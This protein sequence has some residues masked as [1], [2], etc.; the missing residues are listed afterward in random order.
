MKYIYANWC[1]SNNFGDLLTPYIIEHL[2]GGKCIYALPS[3]ETLKY[4]VVGTIL[5][6]DIKNTITWGT[7]IGNR[8]D[9]IQPKDIRSVRGKISLNRMEECGLPTQSISLGDPGLILPTIYSP[10]V[11]QSNEIGIV[12]H[13]VDLEYV[14]QTYSNQFTIINPLDSVES[15]VDQILSC[16]Q[17]ISSSLHGLII[18][19]AYGIDT[20]WVKF[21]DAIGGDGTKFHDHY[22]SIDRHESCIDLRNVNIDSILCTRKRIPES[23]QHGLISTCPF[24]SDI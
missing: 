14:I 8:N 19:E 2:S 15:V 21:S 5:N 10:S 9:I 13:Y 3:S 1:L 11:K 18:A 17:I 6:W 16:R 22:S 23:I 20:Q 24:I 12:P 7:G 4:M